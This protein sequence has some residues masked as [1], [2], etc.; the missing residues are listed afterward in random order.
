MRRPRQSE[1][2]NSPR[3]HNLSTFTAPNLVLAE[4]PDEFQFLRF[5]R[6]RDDVQIHIYEGK[7]Q[8]Q[9][10]L[11]TIRGVEGFGQ[12]Q[13]VG[14][15]R[16]ADQNPQGAVQS[17]LS[18]WANALEET[19]PLVSADDWFQDKEGR[20]WSVWIMPEPGKKGDLEEL[21][22]QAVHIG[23]HRTCI[24]N[25]MDCLDDCSPVPFTSKTK[26][27]LYAWLSTQSNPLKELHAAL[28]PGAGLFDPAD[29]VFERFA[30]LI[31][32]L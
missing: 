23:D 19:I 17:V 4:G 8:L 5:V 3:R 20:R 32:K 7:D 24:N 1:A 27:R 25:L 9:L 15:I 28:R 14:I 31:D 26:A 16:D 30:T 12:V 22:W 2:E 13:Q 10:E 29:P 11:E 21:L 6:P 18:Q